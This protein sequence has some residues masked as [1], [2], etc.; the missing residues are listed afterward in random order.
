VVFT[1][2]SGGATSG[3]E[4]SVKTDITFIAD[5]ANYFTQNTFAVTLPTPESYLY[6]H[7]DTTNNYS[8]L[9]EDFSQ[10][11]GQFYYVYADS[12]LWRR[13]IIGNYQGTLNYNFTTRFNI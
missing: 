6:V 5:R 10:N 11:I 1:Q 8:I 12:R 9:T 2:T 3:I 13:Y 4:V 7:V